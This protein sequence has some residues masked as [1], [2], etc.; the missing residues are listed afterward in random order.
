M[1][2]QSGDGGRQAALDA[3]NANLSKAEQQF[4][5]ITTPDT[6]AQELHL[7]TPVLQGLLKANNIPETALAGISTDPTLRS[8]QMKALQSL[9]ERGAS[10]L[11]PEDKQMF[12]QMQQKGAAAYQA[13]QSGIQQSLAERGMGGSGSE[14]LQKIAAS[15]NAANQQQSA[16]MDIAAQS[17]AAKRQALAQAGQLSGQLEQEDYQKAANLANARDAINRMNTQM[18]NQV[19]AQNL[20][21]QQQYSDQATQIANQQQQYN[22]A[23]LQKQYENQMNLAGTKAGIYAGG[24]QMNLQQAAMARPSQGSPLLGV[25][26]GL[27]GAVGGAYLGN[28]I[29]PGTGLSSGLSTSMA[30]QGNAMGNYYGGY[31]PGYRPYQADGGIINSNDSAKFADGGL[32]GT[33]NTGTAGNL[34]E[35]Y[36]NKLKDLV[37]MANGGISFKMPK[38]V[39]VSIGTPSSDGGGLIAQIKKEHPN[40]N[41]IDATKMAE[42]I[43]HKHS[44]FADGGSP[45]DDAAAIVGG[46]AQFA[47]GG[48]TESNLGKLKQM[49]G[50]INRWKVNGDR[51]GEKVITAADGVNSSAPLDILG[52][53]TGKPTINSSQNL[54]PNINPKDIAFNQ[55]AIDAQNLKDYNAQK[56]WDEQEAIDYRKHLDE[57]KKS[58]IDPEILNA[59]TKIATSLVPQV[60]STP[61]HKPEKVH[62]GLRGEFAP[63]GAPSKS[64]FAEGGIAESLLGKFKSGPNSSNTY[65]SSGYITEGE[66]IWGNLSSEEKEYLSKKIDFQKTK[67]NPQ[68]DVDKWTPG[69]ANGGLNYAGN[70]D[71]AKMTPQFA[72][73]GSDDSGKIKRLL[74]ATDYGSTSEI[75]N[76]IMKTT[77]AISFYKDAAEKGDKLAA[78]HLKSLGEHLDTV[79][80]VL[81]RGAKLSVPLAVGAG[82]ARVAL[83]PEA[84]IASEVLGSED[85]GAGSD[86][87][88]GEPTASDIT[89][90]KQKM[91][92]NPLPNPYTQ[93]L[94]Q[95]TTP[96]PNQT[97]PQQNYDKGGVQKKGPY[98]GDRVDAK[99]N[100]G[101]MVLNLDQQQRLMD[102]LRGHLRPAEIPKKDIVEP[103][104]KEDTN[105]HK[106]NKELE[107]RV[108][109]LEKLTRK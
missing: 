12:S 80:G 97:Q 42:A 91:D 109:A 88:K 1:G 19:A 38:P 93:K 53:I 85:V 27:G 108:H 92:A 33:A 24:A 74:K 84:A 30:N 67:N 52:T 34:K 95:S 23:L 43:W 78:L 100:N 65:S 94:D 83:G 41:D 37:H 31:T 29:A 6:V 73:G 64:G 21:L 55:A 89:F 75:A 70:I 60:A 54:T 17:A 36:S 90:I 72:D 66:D 47:E 59:A 14:L 105:L 7:E 5:G 10:G 81:A 87:T 25:L 104:D 35:T 69:F 107:A 76:D 82:V 46:D 44:K 45:T 103:S 68:Y 48:V 26:G 32:Q 77:N 8:A 62:F 18:Q 96:N 39:T 102:L 57:Q 2:S 51:E 106:K 71:E 101:E 22:K 11:T 40:M 20:G 15:Q 98:V 86:I 4:Q 16:G 63:I 9:Q 49:L 58:K 3:M 28:Q 79:K 56:A 99:I 50:K 61:Q 13:Q